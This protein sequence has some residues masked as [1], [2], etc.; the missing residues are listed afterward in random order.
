LGTRSR[1]W[2]EPK[3]KDELH[4]LHFETL[5]RDKSAPS[6]KIVL[7]GISKEINRRESISDIK[8]RDQQEKEGRGSG[9]PGPTRRTEQDEEDLLDAYLKT[10]RKAQGL[11]GKELW[12]LWVKHADIADGDTA[13]L[14]EFLLYKAYTNEFIARYRVEKRGSLGPQESSRNSRDSAG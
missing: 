8:R 10:R 6:R 13:S 9:F 12:S 5:K 2:L 11:E 1:S 4:D 14:K 3:T 7:D